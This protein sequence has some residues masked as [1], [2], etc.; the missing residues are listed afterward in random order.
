MSV[1][2][3]EKFTKNF[4]AEKAAAAAA[5]QAPQPDPPTPATDAAGSGDEKVWDTH[6]PQS[7][8]GG[9]VIMFA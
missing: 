8:Q 1:A 3:K 7:G 5:L 4:K 2:D 6:L 9:F